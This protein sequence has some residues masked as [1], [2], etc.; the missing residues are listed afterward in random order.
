MVLVGAQR[1]EAAVLDGR[2]HAAERLTD[3]A[4][5]GLCSITGA[6]LTKIL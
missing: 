6:T 2:D 5:G 1:D 4:E 3:P